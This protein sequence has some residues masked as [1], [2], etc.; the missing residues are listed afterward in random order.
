MLRGIVPATGGMTMALGVFFG[1][2]AARKGAIGLF[3]WAV[4]VAAGIL[5]GVSQAPVLLILVGAAALGAFTA[6]FPRKSVEPDQP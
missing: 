1:K 3:D 4:I 2:T 6:Y 5:V